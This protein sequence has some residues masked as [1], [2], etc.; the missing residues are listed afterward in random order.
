MTEHPNYKYRPRRRKHNKQRAAPTS[1][2][3]PRV[4]PSLSS[5]GQGP[6]GASHSSNMSDITMSPRYSSYVPNS[7]G[8]SP[9][10]STNQYT[11]STMDY[12]TASSSTDYSSDNKRQNYSP[13]TFQQQK[14][15]YQGFQNYYQTYPKSPYILHTPESSPTQSP[16]P[17]STQLKQAPKSPQDLNNKDGNNS[18]NGSNS[19]PRDENTPVLPTPEMSPLEQEKENFQYSEEKRSAQSNNSSTGGITNVTTS[20]NNNYRIQNYRQPNNNT[21]SYTNSQP[22]TSMPMAN[23]VY[24]MCA[25]RS[26]VEQGH[27]V[28]GTFFPPVATSQ[29]HQLLGVNNQTLNTTSGST[30]NNM[31]N[32]FTSNI[33]QYYQPQKDFYKNENS[34]TMLEDKSSQD[35]YS[36]SSYKTN[37]LEQQQKDYD[38]YK[39]NMEANTYYS[40]QMVQPYI[41]AAITDERSDVES[42]VDA[43]EFDK[44]LKFT[45]DQSTMIDSNHNY[46][47][48][49]NSMGFGF[50][51]PGQQHQSV[52]LQNTNVIKTESTNLMSHYN[53]DLYVTPNDISQQVAPKTD[54]DFSEI[55]ADVRKTCYSN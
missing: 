17:K 47:R 28:T 41:Q 21:I 38:L 11:S 54:D 33:T 8:L 24:V 7:A 5:P 29:D 37:L 16:E 4:T 13:V 23:G 43:R 34:T 45:T 10:T 36:I 40:S 27:V 49:E 32:Y 14:L 15:G 25:N 53:H 46:H 19:N 2:T 44:Y 30:S 31:N 3:S 35:P 1:A 26:S 55:L 12:T 50:Q 6:L 18:N 52:I 9:S 39:S 51:T 48:N 22:I 42:D 20:S